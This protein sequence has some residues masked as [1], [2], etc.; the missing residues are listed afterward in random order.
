MELLNRSRR[1]RTSSAI[2]AMVRENSLSV[3]DFI[4]PLFVQE[5]K[6]VKSE[7]PSMPGYFRY[8]LDTLTEELHTI[9]GLGLKSVLVFVKVGDEL[10]DNSGKEAFNPNGFMQET[11][12]HIKAVAPELYIM[13]DVALDPYSS[14]GHDGIVSNGKIVND[15]TVE[16]LCKMAVSHA[17]AGADMVAPSDMMD[18][19]VLALRQALDNAGYQ[20]VGI[21]SYA[22]KYASSFYGPFR[23]ALDSAPVDMKDIPKDK[24]TYQMDPANRKEAIKEILQDVEQGADILMVKPGM[25]Y[26][27]IVRDAANEIEQPISVYQVSGEY[28]M[29]KAAVA[30]GWLNEKEVVLESLIAFKR[31]GASLIASYFAKDVAY[32]L[33][34]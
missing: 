11:I 24:K 22:A 23:E 13:T 4:V 9:L 29:I 14:V 18:G 26:L 5:G 33:K 6:G 32:W 8:S 1:L 28:A 27:D 16:T 17:E 21:M 30:N 31:A 20:D 19:R 34:E 3:D 12:K 10:K 2:R 7:I 15:P 25:P